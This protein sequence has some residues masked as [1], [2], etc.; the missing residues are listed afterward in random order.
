MAQDDDIRR[1]YRRKA[2]DYHPDRFP[3]DSQERLQAEEQFLVLTEA[4]DTLLDPERRD[5]YDKEQSILQQAWLDANRQ[6]YDIPVNPPPGAKA[7]FQDALQKAFEHAQEDA[8]FQRADFLVDDQGARIY[9]H[10]S[11]DDHDDS[12]DKEAKAQRSRQ[13]SAAFYYAQGM[14]FAARGQYRRAWYALSNAQML[15]PEIDIPP[16]V[17]HKIR[18]YAYYTRR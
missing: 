6:H 12:S 1:A 7:N 16:H 4:R 5:A 13:N 15:D 18:T 3:L 9:T 10:S 11:D 2:L 17:M 14:R 8:D